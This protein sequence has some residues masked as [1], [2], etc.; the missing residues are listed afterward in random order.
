MIHVILQMI[1][2]YLKSKFYHNYLKI[3]VANNQIQKMRK[4]QKIMMIY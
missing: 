4:K 2:K 1:L 3:A